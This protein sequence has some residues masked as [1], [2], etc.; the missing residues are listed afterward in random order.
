MRTPISFLMNRQKKLLFLRD[1]IVFTLTAFG[2][3]PSHIAS[4]LRNFVHRRHYIKEQEL[5]ELN[6]LTQMLPGP[7]STQTLVGIAWKVGGTSLALLTLII[8]VL[9]SS[10]LLFLTAYFYADCQQVPIIKVMLNGIQP[11]AI[12]MLIYAIVMF[13]KNVFKDT[14]TGVVVFVSLVL[15]IFIRNAYAFPLLLVFGGW[16]SAKWYTNKGD[17]TIEWHFFKQVNKKKLAYFLGVLFLGAF[18]GAVVERTSPFSLPIRL[19]ENFYRNG[20]IVLGGGQVLV[21]LMLT[22]FV[23]MKHYLT[24]VEFLTGF[25]VQQ[26]LPGPVFSFS[27]FLG[28]MSVINQGGGLGFQILGALAAVIGLNLPGF[29]LILFIV[30]F[31][32][33]LRKIVQVKH[34]LTGINAVALGFMIASIWFLYQGAIFNLS[35]LILA[36]ASFLVLYYT[37][38]NL[39]IL[40]LASVG[41][42]FLLY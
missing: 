18:L 14:L 24:E 12:A 9:P 2:G 27:S 40:V 17:S 29:I 30:P 20:I 5:M 41:I 16:V 36:I 25:S 10:V 31:W 13:A 33:D 35:S 34:F 26:V 8:W 15:A 39:F 23:E 3:P 1:V 6:T 28:A 42:S 19:F 37:S 32:N 38:I 4:M 7:S 21:S 22:E 11:V